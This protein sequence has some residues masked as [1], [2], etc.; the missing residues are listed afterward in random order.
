MRIFHAL[1]ANQVGV[2]PQP[3]ERRAAFRRRFPFQLA[4]AIFPYFTAGSGCL[5]E[6]AISGSQGA[7][8]AV[9]APCPSTSHVA[10][11]HVR[12]RSPIHPRA[13]EGAAG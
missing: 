13:K 7:V 3:R 1:A 11:A 12:R 9:P 2:F 6:T 4:A 5:D 8:E 10:D